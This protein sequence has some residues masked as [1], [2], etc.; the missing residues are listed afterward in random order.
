MMYRGGEKMAIDNM[1]MLKFETMIKKINKDLDI[2]G[3]NRSATGNNLPLKLVFNY[4]KL[5]EFGKK[6]I[7]ITSFN[8]A[9]NYNIEKW[10]KKYS[11]IHEDNH[12]EAARDFIALNEKGEALRFIFWALM[13]LTVDDN[14]R[15]EKLTLICDFI[16]M[17]D[18]TDE[19]V[20]DLINVIK[21]IYKKTD[22]QLNSVDVNMYFGTLIYNYK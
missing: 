21:M 1:R 20:S 16:K 7:K 2:Y 11:I 22:I 15:D 6:I 4:S 9:S 3:L 10:E 13:I 5:N 8:L 18:I 14:D 12:V 19:E 17:L